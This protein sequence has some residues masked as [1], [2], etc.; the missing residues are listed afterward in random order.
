MRAARALLGWTQDRLAQKSGLS[1]LTIKNIEHGKTS[2]RVVTMQWVETA[3]QLGGVVW[4]PED[5][6]GG[7]GVRFK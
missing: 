2:P 4:F 6:D 1:V 7:E 5:E 3:L